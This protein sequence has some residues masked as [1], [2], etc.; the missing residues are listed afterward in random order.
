MLHLIETYLELKRVAFFSNLT[1]KELR[2][3]DLIQEYPKNQNWSM[4]KTAY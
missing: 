1:I 2:L 3:M 4:I